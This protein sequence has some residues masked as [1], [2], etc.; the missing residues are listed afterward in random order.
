MLRYVAVC[1]SALQCHTQCASE[2]L[3]LWRYDGWMFHQIAVC[4]SE[5]HYVAVSDTVVI[6][7]AL[8]CYIRCMEMGHLCK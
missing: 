8:Q 7:S 5:M 4:C 1:C 3:L 2:R 6:F